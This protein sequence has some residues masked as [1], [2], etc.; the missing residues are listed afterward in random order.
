MDRS[1]FMVARFRSFVQLLTLCLV[2]GAAMLV[3]ASPGWS[4]PPGPT[5]RDRQIA[6]TVVSLLKRDHLSKHP[7]DDEVSQ[8]CFQTFLKMLDPMKL[9]FTQADVDE[10]ARHQFELDDWALRGD[11]SFLE[12]AQRVFRRFLQRVDERVKLVDELLAMQH[13]FTAE[14]EML[15]DRKLAQYAKDDEEVRTR[16]RKRIKFDLLMLKADKDKIEG[17]AAVEKLHRRYHSFAKRMHQTDGEELLEMYLTSFTTAFDPH[18]TYMAPSTLENFEIMMRLGLEGIGAALKSED[19]Y[20]VVDKIVPG[21]AA[22]KQG[23]L[24]V[25]DRIIGV[26]QGPD[27]PI[28]DVMDMRLSDVVKLIRGKTGTIVRLEVLSG[29][30]GQRKIIQITRAKIELKDSEAQSRIFPVGKKPNGQPYLLGVIDL[31][32]FYMDMNAARLGLPGY[33]STT[34]DVRRILEQFNAQGVD[35]V[36]LD[37]RRNGGGSLQEAINLTGL[38]TGEGPV[39]QVKDAEGRVQPY[40]DVAPG[41]VWRGPLVVLVSKFSASASEIFAAA[42]QDYRRGLIVGDYSTHGKGTVQSLMELGQQ[43]F[44]L[45]NAPQLGALKITMQ[46]FYRLNGDSTQKRGVLA[47]IELPSLT[48][49]LDVAEADL[50]YPIPFDQVRPLEFRRFDMIDK[51]MIERLAAQS[52]QRVNNSQ[53]FQKVLKNIARY[54]AQKERKYVTLNEQKFLQERAELNAD[55]EEEKQI[56][57]MS[58]PSTAGIE[59]NYYLDEA[60]AI[61]VDYLDLLHRARGKVGAQVQAVR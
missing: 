19:G 8:R 48:T 55:K 57:K 11:V 50:D 46:Q 16:W 14:E 20:T 52:A 59:R 51:A 39:V 27:G 2:S 6:L 54:R 32:S 45:P 30:T 3:P 41:P 56:E 13:D 33:R 37:L 31:P 34:R 58:E 22:E 10:F 35:A 4:D 17:P 15:I 18:T 21:G 60:M 47:D 53:D 5:A 26:G 28:Q 38:F 40:E 24:K 1:S 12:F 43:L 9:Y 23:Q 29:P 61:T 36:I 7:I 49:H 42:I 44:R 25:E